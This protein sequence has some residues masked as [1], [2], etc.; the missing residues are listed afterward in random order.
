MSGSQGIGLSLHQ[1]PR[2]VLRGTRRVCFGF[3]GASKEYSTENMGR[4]GVGH[5]ELRFTARIRLLWMR[6]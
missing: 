1:D 5:C 4:E 3:C 2:Q 6:A